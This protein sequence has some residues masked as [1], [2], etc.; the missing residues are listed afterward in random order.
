MSRTLLST[1]RQ[2]KW[3]G[4]KENKKASE[5]IT[6]ES[7]AHRGTNRGG[8]KESKLLTSDSKERDE[9]DEK[10]EQTV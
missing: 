1:P 7:G 6:M 10:W 5:G 2:P 8:K 3:K 4:K 9:F